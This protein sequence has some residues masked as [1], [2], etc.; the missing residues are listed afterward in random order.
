MKKKLLIASG[1]LL[2]VFAGM[3]FV[4]VD[5][6]NPTVQSD[7]EAPGEIKAILVKACYDCHSNETR[8]PW[9]SRV[10]P[11]SWLVASDVHEAREYLNFSEWGLLD[12]EDQADLRKEI[13]NEVER[14]KM[15]L[16]AYALMNPGARLTDEEKKMLEAWALGAAEDSPAEE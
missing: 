6:T 13:W 8:W 15:P 5:R 7:L 4:A 10:A 1:A 2:V 16:P 9:Y 12:P 11:V 14:N 3:Q